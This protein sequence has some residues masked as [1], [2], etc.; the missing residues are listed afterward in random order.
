M[1]WTI[2]EQR[3]LRKAIR[4]VRSWTD[5]SE[6]YEVIEEFF[7]DFLDESFYIDMTE[8]WVCYDDI[9]WLQQNKWQE[10]ANDKITNL[11]F[12]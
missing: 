10:Y 7:R 8:K 3:K 2:H 11:L 1:K 12:N 9:Y 4:D 5:L 6:W